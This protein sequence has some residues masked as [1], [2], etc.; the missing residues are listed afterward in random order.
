MEVWGGWVA[1]AAECD[2]DHDGYVAGYR[3]AL[4]YVFEYVEH[5]AM[6][7]TGRRIEADGRGLKHSAAFNSGLESA[8]HNLLAWISEE[9]EDDDEGDE[10]KRIA[11]GG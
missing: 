5:L 11:G 2:H 10:L 4:D 6:D 9:D 1:V 3:H 8:Y 7:A